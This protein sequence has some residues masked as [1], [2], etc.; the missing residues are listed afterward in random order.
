MIATSPVTEICVGMGEATRVQLTWWRVFQFQTMAGCWCLR[1][2]SNIVQN[3]HHR[4]LPI[5]QFVRAFRI[6][7]QFFFRSLQQ[8]LDKPPALQ[9]Q[10]LRWSSQPYDVSCI[11]KHQTAHY[12]PRPGFFSFRTRW[13][14]QL[15]IGPRHRWQRLQQRW[16]RWQQL[17]QQQR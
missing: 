15:R 3:N 1:L 16:L 17:Q 2:F 14:H 8:N 7:T 12:H 13:K 11:E 10:Q 5:N 6:K 4:I 9:Q